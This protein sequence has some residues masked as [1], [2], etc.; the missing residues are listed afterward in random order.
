M[1]GDEQIP[2]VG[3][4]I[5]LGLSSRSIFNE[6]KIQKKYFNEQK[7]AL[8]W[9]LHLL[10]VIFLA[11]RERKV[12]SSTICNLQNMALSGLCAPKHTC[13]TWQHWTSAAV[14]RNSGDD[15]SKACSVPST[16]MGSVPNRLPSQ[17]LLKAI[18]SEPQLRLCSLISISCG[19]ADCTVENLMICRESM[20]SSLKQD[21]APFSWNTKNSWG[22]WNPG[23]CLLL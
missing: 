16:S 1:S 11:F 14:R 7:S 17:Q 8:F 5:S 22:T 15:G 19:E 13:L 23:V 2:S 20:S 18:S 21:P 4:V 9:N 10:A 12:N 3:V 6:Q